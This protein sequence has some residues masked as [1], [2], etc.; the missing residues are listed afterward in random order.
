MDDSHF[1]RIVSE[2][3]EKYDKRL[4]DKQKTLQNRIDKQMSKINKDDKKTKTEGTVQEHKDRKRTLTDVEIAN[5]VD[6][7]KQRLC[8]TKLATKAFLENIDLVRN[9]FIGQEFLTKTNI[10]QFIDAGAKMLSYST[11]MILLTTSE[12]HLPLF[13]FRIPVDEISRDLHSI[14]NPWKV[15]DLEGFGLNLT[16]TL[17]IN[18]KKRYLLNWDIVTVLNQL[19]KMKKESNL[20]ELDANLKYRIL[21]GV[22]LMFTKLS[23]QHRFGSFETQMLSIFQSKQ[24][25]SGEQ[26]L[27][28]LPKEI[29]KSKTQKRGV[30]LVCWQYLCHILNHYRGIPFYLK[31]FDKTGSVS[32]L[33][34]GII[35]HGT[36]PISGCLP[37]VLHALLN[38]CLAE[39]LGDFTTETAKIYAKHVCACGSESIYQTQI[40]TKSVFRSWTKLAFD[41]V[42]YV[43]V[44]NF[45]ENMEMTDQKIEFI[46]EEFWMDD[47]EKSNLLSSV[48]KLPIYYKN[49]VASQLKI[50]ETRRAQ[51]MKTFDQ[52]KKENFNQSIDYKECLELLTHCVNSTEHL[53]WI[54]MTSLSIS[55]F[56]LYNKTSLLLEYE[57]SVG[58]KIV[59]SVEKAEPVISLITPSGKSIPLQMKW[60]NKVLAQLSELFNEK[61]YDIILNDYNDIVNFESRFV[62]YLTN[63]SGG[64]KSEEPTLSKELKGISNARIIAFALNFSSYYD[65]PEFVKMIMRM[66]KCAIRF[67]ID[68]RARIIVIVPNAIQTNELFLLLAF[69]SIKK[70][71]EAGLKMAV[72]KQVGN[73]LDAKIQMSHSGRVNDLKNSGDMK[74][75]DAH[76]IPTITQFLRYKVIDVMLQIKNDISRGKSSGYFFSQDKEYD[77]FRHEVAYDGRDKLWMKGIAVHAAKVLFYMYNMTMELSD[78]F[79][80][81]SMDVS[82]HTFQSGFFGTSAQHTMLIDLVITYCLRR[83][84]T[85]AENKNVQLVHSIMGDDIFEVIKNGNLFKDIVKEWLKFRNDTFKELNYEEEVDISR[86]YGVFLQQ[87]ALLGCYVPFSP[88]VSLFCDERTETQKR[89]PVD[90]IKIALDVLVTRG[91]RAYGIDNM[92]GIGYSIWNSYRNCKYMLED[93]GLQLVNKMVKSTEFRDLDFITVNSRDKSLTMLYPFVLIMCAPIGWPMLSF[94]LRLYGR[95]DVIFR[96]KSVT[97]PSG[98]VAII[99]INQM[100]Y[101]SEHIH[102]LNI[103][104]FIKDNKQISQVKVDDEYINWDDR[105]SWL[106]TISEHILKFKR[107]RRLTET[108]KD[109]LGQGDIDVMTHNLNTFLNKDMLAQSFSSS[110]RLIEAGIKVP[111]S[112]LYINHSRTK[113]EQS[114][115]VRSESLEEKTLID[116]YFLQH[117]SKYSRRPK[118]TQDK[119]LHYLCAIRPRIYFDYEYAQYKEDFIEPSNDSVLNLILPVLPGYHRHS[120]YAKLL[121]Y[122]TLPSTL[123]R[124][125]SGILGELTGSLGA[126]FDVESAIEFGGYVSSINHELLTD[127]AVAIG[128]PTKFIDRYVKLVENYLESNFNVKYHS[129]F[130]SVKYFGLSGN[131]SHFGKHVKYDSE[132][133]KFSGFKGFEKFNNVFARDLIFSN[134]DDLNDRILHIEYSIYS[135]LTIMTRGSLKYF[136]Q[137][138]HRLFAPQIL[139]SPDDSEMVISEL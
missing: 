88:R 95:D 55:N 123:D 24:K 125:I 35:F 94:S 97:S 69:N 49:F 12:L 22:F 113:I 66:G 79:F 21:K 16:L 37:G 100:F 3:A 41:R 111:S 133:L 138:L 39:L 127:A 7:F 109:V 137:H 90:V 112:L 56:G 50:I 63:K 38:G 132:L 98:D 54:V 10:S 139:Y 33:E 23:N 86:I 77:I 6:E 103:S 42:G 129:I 36:K 70:H 83:F 80:G 105:H 101:M 110:N 51:G 32:V 27:V 120:A 93:K 135:L 116:S 25:L 2:N 15:F 128:I 131:L 108:R 118:S 75:M 73:L 31:K 58:T 122:T 64:I 17:S 47:D 18:P 71:P 96:A 48:K 130:Q 87:A 89:N 40:E 44:N 124:N 65:E 81:R 28:N 5:I 85:K 52:Y 76:T 26:M 8:S 53:R 59:K 126:S 20:S 114:L 34:E 60:S 121:R 13:E 46:D 119:N 43:L 57:K 107:L 117:I 29:K 72:G 78:D 134:V 102:M 1:L 136:D 68:R 30:D 61:W 115:A 106:F 45:T 91:Q 19:V 62:T 92:T 82:D 11:D 4:K 99:N 67:Q 104:E 84:Y 74:G 9:I 14:L